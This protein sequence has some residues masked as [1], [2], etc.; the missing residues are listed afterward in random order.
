M[1]TKTDRFTGYDALWLIALAVVVTYARAYAV[2]V[3][4]HSAW[5][6]WTTYWFIGFATVLTWVMAVLGMVLFVVDYKKKG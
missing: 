4:D 2:S 3:M 1:S 6:Y 5:W